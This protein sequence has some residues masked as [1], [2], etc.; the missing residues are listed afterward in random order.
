MSYTDPGSDNQGSD[1]VFLTVIGPDGQ[2]RPI[3]SLRDAVE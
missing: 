2:Y 1:R 3:E